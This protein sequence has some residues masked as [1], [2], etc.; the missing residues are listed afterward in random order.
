MKFIKTVF[1]I[2]ILL[3]AIV[4]HSQQ[5]IVFEKTYRTETS[6]TV[7]MALTGAQTSDGGY[8]L[9]GYA[10]YGMYLAQMMFF[11]IDSVGNYQWK[12]MYGS[13]PCSSNMIHDM[14]PVGDGT[15]ICCGE[16][17][18]STEGEPGDLKPTNSMIMRVDENAN[19]LWHKEFDLGYHEELSEVALSDTGFLCAG[20][21]TN[22]DKMVDELLWITG[23][24][25]GNF[26]NE[27][28]LNYYDYNSQLIR[29]V[30][31][32]DEGNFVMGGGIW[33][34][35]VLL[36][37]DHQGDTIKTVILGSGFPEAYNV[38]D[39]SETPQGILFCGSFS[40]DFVAH[41]EYLAFYNNIDTDLFNI[42]ENYFEH[43]NEVK[44]SGCQKI[45]N[46]NDTTILIAGSMRT[47]GRGVDF[48]LKKISSYNEIFWERSIGGIESEN[49]RDVIETKDGG[50]LIIGESES[51]DQ[52]NSM[53]VVKTDSLGLGNYT[54]PVEEYE[55]PVMNFSVF[56]NPA[57]SY[58][59]INSN[60]RYSEI[61]VFDISGKIIIQ[62][63]TTDNQTTIKTEHL[64]SGV[65]VVK[66]VSEEKVNTSKLIIN[67]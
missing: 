39:I 2:F 59:I 14:E 6:D 56:P 38:Y 55:I 60:N 21:L 23:D 12:K 13:L 8:L 65:Y 45:L 35:A 40:D 49:L 37:I 3:I 51:F 10:A 50:Y 66:S 29:G 43:E 7:I 9:G 36:K 27:H 25:E 5:S 17:T 4:G 1:T 47:I 58:F 22:F 64:P 31:F 52:Y 67:H 33:N 24:F 46:H 11:K 57:D 53:Y 42:Y 44:Y 32:L 34:N 28:T 19:I 15:F 54:S 63:Q 16:G 48:W 62:T 41:N 61:I 30:A 26:V 18:F 20:Y